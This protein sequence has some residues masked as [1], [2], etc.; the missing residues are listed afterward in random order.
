[1]GLE[2]AP[3]APPV[4]PEKSPAVFYQKIGELDWKPELAFQAHD[5]FVHLL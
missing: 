4:R 1:V 5:L 2:Y 3:A